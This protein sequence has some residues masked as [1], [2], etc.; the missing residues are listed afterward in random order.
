VL[1]VVLAFQLIPNSVE[2]LRPI[3]KDPLS[4]PLSFQLYHWLNL[5]IG[6]GPL[7]DWQFGPR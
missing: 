6:K 7:G 3:I 1:N 4:F 5:R 2:H